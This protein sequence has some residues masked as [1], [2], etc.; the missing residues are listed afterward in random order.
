M[1]TATT[2]TTDPLNLARYCLE[3]S[4]L[5]PARAARPAFTFV[6]PEV[7][8][9]TWTYAEVWHRIEAIARG[10]IARDIAR[11]ERVLVRL[12]HSPDY[13]FAFFGATLAGLVPIP[14]SPMLTDEE[15]TF[16]L[17]DSGA[18]AIIA[19]TELH[20]AAFEGVTVTPEELATLDGPPPPSGGP[21][22]HPLPRT[23]AEDPA[24]LIYTSGTTSKPKGVLHA[25]RTVRGRALMREGWQ[26]F[27]ETDTTLH[28]G[29]L[30]WSYTLGVGLMDA[31]AA[32]AHAILKGGANEP[33]TWP[34]LIERLGVTIFIAVPTVYR[35][36]LKYARPE[37]HDL[38]SLRHVLC[39]GEPLTPALYQ[40]WRTRV[41]TEMYESLG[42]TEV[43]TYISSGPVT[44]VHVGSPGRPQPGRR[45]AILPEDSD[46][47]A[48]LPPNTVGLLAV[49]RS[50]PGLML[51][52]WNR[53]DEDAA[54]FRG[55][56]FIGGDRASL[57]D[58]GY[59]HFNGR[60]DDVIKS[61]GYRLSPVEIE[62]TLESH[63]AVL[64]AA[65][66]GFAVDDQ[67]T[68]VTACVV[69]SSPGALTIADLETYASEHLAEYK[70]PHQYRLVQ[71]L[72]RTRNGKVQ[73]KALLED[74][75]RGA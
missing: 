45:V 8:D 53:P 14:A 75:R 69:P 46:S 6:D 15:A 39:A 36:L 37:D 47:T 42:M 40:E 2:A 34:A 70:R 33:G 38:S 9:R 50:D 10:L 25:H 48:P 67:K 11:G 65:V 51:H 58:D 23:N 30:N 74:L 28:A 20:P 1:T 55:E 12:P 60:A 57:D 44:P 21:N 54:V 35:Q 59:V 19:P 66:V 26:G 56:W 64:E 41:G 61:F 22:Q 13:A 52:Y 31:W 5:D 24:F 73:R 32:G 63:P 27:E 4:A 29:T 49:H 68:L 16:L 18:S 62:A 7:G 3:A 72:P 71:A 43:S 17:E